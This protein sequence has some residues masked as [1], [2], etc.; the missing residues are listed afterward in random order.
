MSRERR[1]HVEELAGDRPTLSSEEA[2]HLIDVLRLREGAEVSV[3]D[4]RGNSARAKVHRIAGREVEL[5]I[6]GSEPSR[7]SPL[8]LTLAVAPPK[9]DRM[10]FLVEKLTELGVVC[11]IPLDTERGRSGKSLDRWRRIALEAC[12]QSGRSRAPTVEEARSVA[13][14]LEVPGL[15]LAAHPGA[16]AL[17][18]DAPSRAVALVGPEGGWSE[19]E[20]SLFGSR[21]VTLFGLGPRT[22]R[23][24]TAAIAVATLFQ[25]LRGDLGAKPRGN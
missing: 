5:R 8:A 14:V 15:K 2:H 25:Y 6:L 17:A 3:F 16:P 11:L 9:G 24:E 18:A 22:L 12:K 4:G 20:L 23:T 1:F 10:S 7:E 19:S 21:G 13:S